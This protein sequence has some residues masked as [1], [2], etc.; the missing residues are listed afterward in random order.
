M[1]T[2]RVIG[3]VLMGLIIWRVF[4]PIQLP[5]SFPFESG[6]RFQVANVIDGDTIALTDGRRV[7]TGYQMTS[8][9]HC[10]LARLEGDRFQPALCA[11][12]LQKR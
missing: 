5:E 3:L 8:H 1:S 10:V 12:P 2:G 7:V 6:R 4:H 9:K 11:R